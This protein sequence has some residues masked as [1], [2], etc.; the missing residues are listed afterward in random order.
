MDKLKTVIHNKSS[1]DKKYRYYIYS[2]INPD[3]LPS[4]FLSCVNNA[5]AITRFRLGPHNLPIET[6]RWS[7]TPRMGRLCPKCD[8]LGDEYHFLFY[9][10]EVVWDPSYTF[11]GTLHEVWTNENVFRLFNESSNVNSCKILIW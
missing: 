5:D 9:F 7:R 8:I 2:K 4:I 3:L 1:S 6:G 11:T 10:S